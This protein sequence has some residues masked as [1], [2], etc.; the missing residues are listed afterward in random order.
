MTV[1][2]RPA[3]DLSVSYRDG[4]P[5]FHMKG[6]LMD[7]QQADRL[8]E[9]LNAE[10]GKGPASVVLD[11]VDLQYMNSTGL[12]ILISVLTTTRNKGGDTLIANVSTSVRQLFL[13]TKLDSVFIITPSVEEAIAKLKG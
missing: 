6:R 5:V 9:S 2:E 12:N 4:I 11:M 1:T 7:Q 8:M 3:F 10:L 13:V